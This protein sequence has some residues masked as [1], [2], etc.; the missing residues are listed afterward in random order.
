MKKFLTRIF[1]AV[2]CAGVM[3]STAMSAAAE[4]YTVE[5]QYP[6]HGNKCGVA[7]I[8]PEIDRD[9]AV[10]ITQ[11]TQDG[12]YV[13]YDTVIPA[14]G[15]NTGEDRY[16]FVLEGKNDVTYRISLGVAKYKGSTDYQ[17]IEY[18]FAIPDTD[19]IV[20]GSVTG[21][22]QG[23]EILRNDELEAP[24]LTSESE[25]IT[26]ENGLVWNSCQFSFPASDIVPG[27]VDF[28]EVIDLYD[29][30][31]IARYIA[32]PT[33]LNEA[34]ITAADYNLDG[35]TNLYDAVDLAKHIM[36]M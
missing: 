22:V 32:D 29:V 2:M 1:A 9:I 20:D 33:S 27:D 3:L 6:I 19:E 10:T 5:P 24:E 35:I 23:F 15:E 34:Q 7:A 28:N 14:G 36:G 16:D 17:Y 31:A 25:E 4:N 11:L 21:Y 26:D 8:L 13:Y 30:I 18:D 12:D